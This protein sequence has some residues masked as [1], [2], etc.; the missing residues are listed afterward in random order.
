M[1][2]LICGVTQS[3][4]TTLAR[5]IAR[6]LADRGERGIVYDPVGSNTAGGAWPETFEV[7]QEP[8]EFMARLN[9]PTLSDAHIFVDEADEIF[10]LS[11]RD[12]FWLPKKGRH[13]LFRVY[14]I[15][16]RPTMIAPTA[17]KQA[18]RCYMFRLAID[19]AKELAANFGFSDIH[20]E[21]LDKGDFIVLDSG[22]ASTKRAN[23]FKLLS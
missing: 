20:K 14:M 7:Y 16:Q 4:K 21:I 3:G 17:R 12:N 9:D 10:S 15:T 18:G 8:D 1:H 2:V 11:D 13:F 22:Q 19:D 5:A 6:D 23:I